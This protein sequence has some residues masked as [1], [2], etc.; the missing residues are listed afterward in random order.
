MATEGPRD[1]TLA[2]RLIIANVIIRVG[3]ALALVA[4][5][6]TNE[7]NELDGWDIARFWAIASDTGRHWADQAVE[8]PPGSVALIELL[9]IS[10]VVWSHRLIVVASLLVDLAIV[11]GLV[12]FIGRTGAATYLVLS[13]P[14]V[15]GGLVR[16][17]LWATGLAVLAFAALCDDGPKRS[18][19]GW[20]AAAAIVAGAAVKVMP[21][22]IVIVAI[23]RRRWSVV[24]ATIGGGLAATTA[25]LLYGGTDAVSQVLSLRDATGWHVES[26]AGAITTLTTDETARF[27][28]DVFRIGEID[29]RILWLGRGLLACLAGL[30]VGLRF[31]AGSRATMEQSRAR[32]TDAAIVVALIAGLLV[33]APLLSPQ[34]LL[35]LTPFVAVIAADEGWRHP[36]VVSA[37]A[38]TLMTGATL[39][40]FGPPGLDVASAAGLLTVRNLLL[41]ALVPLCVRHVMSRHRT[42]EVMANHQ[43]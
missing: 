8:Y 6:W 35:W 17:D 36:I 30:L 41:V 18:R 5:P 39:A 29:E 9:A 2:T 43:R 16:F 34:F 22:V 20:F 7:A 14:L 12:R 31:H 4:G 27:E 15:P 40:A 38:A 3:A 26:V 10:D 21:I 25:W 33:T 23:G 13:L 32:T 11:V 28:A 1:E 24:A 37:G 19:S 42:P